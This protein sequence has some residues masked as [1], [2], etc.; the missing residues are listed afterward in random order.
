MH[1]REVGSLLG[2]TRADPPDPA[3]AELDADLAARLAELE[4]KSLDRFE[5][6]SIRA[7]ATPRGLDVSMDA[8]YGR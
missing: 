7:T 1:V 6:L 5:E 2:A 3:L 4:G 8:H